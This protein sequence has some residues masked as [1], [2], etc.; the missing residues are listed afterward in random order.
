LPDSLSEQFPG[1]TSRDEKK[2]QARVQTILN[3]IRFGLLHVGL[4]GFTKNDQS[5]S[6]EILTYVRK[7]DIVKRDP[8]YFALAT[9]AEML[10]H[11]VHFLSRLKLGISIR[12]P[13]GRQL[14][15]SKL[16]ELVSK[17]ILNHKESRILIAMYK[18]ICI[19]SH[20]KSIFSF[21]S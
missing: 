4:S 21:S 8:G 7:G 15:L 2:S 12:T 18:H 10:D 3:V 5:S 20:C 14:S 13:D 16:L 11:G 9:F 1:N 6:G 17:V 19:G